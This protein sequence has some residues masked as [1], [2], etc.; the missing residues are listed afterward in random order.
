MT[1]DELIDRLTE[2]RE[3]VGGEFLVRGA[4]QPSRV[5]LAE[6]DTV[7]TIMGAGDGNGVFIGL[8]DAR[9]YGSDDHYS[10]DVIDISEE[11][12]E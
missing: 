1:L 10:D 5:L 7:S 9:D 11:D 6:I 3:E 4:F 12:A 8:G 2:I